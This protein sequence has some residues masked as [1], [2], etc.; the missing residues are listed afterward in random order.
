MKNAKLVTQL[1]LVDTRGCKNFRPYSS[2]PVFF[3]HAGL[4]QFS[5]LNSSIQALFKYSGLI[6]VF[7]PYLSIQALF[8]YS[9][10]MQVFIYDYCIEGKNLWSK[11]DKGFTLRKLYKNITYSVLTTLFLHS[12]RWRCERDTLWIRHS[13]IPGSRY[14]TIGTLYSKVGWYSVDKA[15][16]HPW[17]QVQCTNCRVGWFLKI[18][19]SRVSWVFSCWKKSY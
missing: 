19:H 11:W 4:I 16:F 12:V 2:I 5:R 1:S 3:K 17:L 6:Q 15:L 8:K 9:G 10:L 18:V 13:S 14:S 7:R